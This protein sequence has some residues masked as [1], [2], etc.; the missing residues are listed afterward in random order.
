MSLGHSETPR[1]VLHI[2]SVQ[3]TLHVVLIDH[4]YHTQWWYR[5]RFC[6]SAYSGYSENLFHTLHVQYKYECHIHVVDKI[7]HVLELLN[8]ITLSGSQ[9]DAGTMSIMSVMIVTRKSSFFTS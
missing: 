4:T 8:F 7:L 9:Y 1:H 5:A 6:S 2:C 3:R